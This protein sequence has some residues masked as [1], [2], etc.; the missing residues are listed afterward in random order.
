[1]KKKETNNHNKEDVA[2]TSL[3]IRPMMNR[4]NE[5]DRLFENIWG[6]PALRTECDCDFSPRVN[7]EETNDHL[8]LTFELP[9]MD[10]KDIK[11]QVKDRVLTV[12]GKRELKNETKE[13]NTVRSEIWSGLFSRSFTLPESINP[14]KIAADYKNGL[15]E[16]RMDKLEEVKPKEIEVKVS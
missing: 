15:L 10:K 2:M 8:L 6:T 7:I 1:M 16:V 3:M 5:L 11:V 13:G 9:G 4:W 12:S 14:E